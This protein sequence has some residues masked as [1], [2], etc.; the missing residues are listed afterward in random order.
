M[1]KTMVSDAIEALGD[2]TV[3]PDG[4]EIDPDSRLYMAQSPVEYKVR[5]NGKCVKAADMRL[6]LYFDPVRRST[7]LVELDITVKEQQEELDR[8]LS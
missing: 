4:M 6:N 7:E 2:F 1:S 8:M 3:R 5:G